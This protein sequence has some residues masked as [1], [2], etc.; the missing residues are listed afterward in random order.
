VPVKTNFLYHFVT[1]SFLVSTKYHVK[2]DK[3]VDHYPR[4]YV[5]TVETSNKEKEVSK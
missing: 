4:E 5:E 3:D 2:E 1:S